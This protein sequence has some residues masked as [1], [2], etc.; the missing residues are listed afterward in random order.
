[1]SANSAVRVS[2]RVD[3]RAAG[4]EVPRDFIGLSFEMEKLRP[5][6]DGK[7]FF[8]PDNRALLATFETLGIKSLRVGGNTA[9]RPTVPLPSHDDIDSLF[10]F[11]HAAGV[12]VI[13][14]LRLR[15]GSRDEAA[16][17]ARYIVERYASDLACFAI[18][19][20]PNVFAKEYSVYRAEWRRYVD[21]VTAV[22]PQARFCGPSATP[23][24]VAW[25]RDFVKDVADATP[26]VTV[27]QH[28]Y[29]GASGRKVTD[30]AAAR[31]LMLSRTWT[32][33]YQ[34]FHDVFVPTVEAHHLPYR[35]EEAN[36]F[37][38]GG[39]KD[40]S[41]TL[42]AALWAL[43]YMYWWTS[44]G[45]AGI[46]FHTGDEVAAGEQNAPCHYAT[47]VTSNAGYTVR[48]I[49]HALKA[50]DLAG[51]GRLVSATVAPATTELAAY[52]ILDPSGDLSIVLV[53]KA[54]DGDPLAVTIEAD[55]AHPRRRV[56]ELR[57]TA[58]DAAATSVT[59][60]GARIEDDATWKGTW[61]DLGD[62]AAVTLPPA[63]AAIV[64]LERAPPQV[65]SR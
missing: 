38:H 1:M 55:A 5:G 25:A 53:R 7:R 8:R 17:A 24:K 59:L 34:K 13:Y 20:E 62:G 51:R 31:R 28:D 45:A 47:F 63:S 15:E 2:V 41:D 29:P 56:L 3:A 21:A 23:S 36:S 46:N 52:G 39:A 6:P 65:T 18:G 26:L 48:P 44:R 42:A 60:G 43:D 30:P 58:D 10:T 16:A 12:Q 32:N 57:G 54:V 4:P 37:F 11:A 64:R 22:A 50:F 61:T 27:T 19:N 9:D 40:V 35:L 14:T 33:Y 49:G